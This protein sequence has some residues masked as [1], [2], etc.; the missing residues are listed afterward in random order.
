MDGD[1]SGCLGCL[2]TLVAVFL[3]LFLLNHWD[4]I[5]HRLAQFLGLG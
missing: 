5:D 2:A 1:G 3:I 4:Q